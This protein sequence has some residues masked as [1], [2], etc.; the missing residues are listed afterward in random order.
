LYKKAKIRF[1]F[2]QNKLRSKTIGEAKRR[3][4]QDPNYDKPKSPVN[5]SGKGFAATRLN[6][7]NRIINPIP[8]DIQEEL[9]KLSKAS[10]TKDDDEIVM[11]Q[12]KLFPSIVGEAV[13]KLVTGYR[14]ESDMGRRVILQNMLCHI[15]EMYNQVNN[16]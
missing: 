9:N 7:S 13:N 4:Q 1:L 12:I 10:S 3:K 8:L 16:R 15:N 14:Q 11:N 6:T 5:L 2:T